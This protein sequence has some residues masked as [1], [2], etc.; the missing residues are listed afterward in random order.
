MGSARPICPHSW[1]LTMTQ[2]GLPT[3]C[4]NSVVSQRWEYSLYLSDKEIEG[5]PPR[6]AMEEQVTE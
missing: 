1:L 6:W 3:F 4:G 5:P 2:G